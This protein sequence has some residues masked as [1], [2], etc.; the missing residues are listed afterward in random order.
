MTEA[1][2]EE[3]VNLYLDNEIGRHDL[4]DLKQVIREN[5]LRRLKFE[6]ACQ[7]HQ[8][9][10]K[11][12]ATRDGQPSSGDAAAQEERR[13]S[14]AQG[15]ASLPRSSRPSP[16]GDTGSV[17][18][19]SSHSSRKVA[20]GALAASLPGRSKGG[21]VDL[22]KVPLES[23]RSPAVESTPGGSGGAFSFFT[24]PGGLL[25]AVVFAMVGGAGLYTLL[26]LNSALSNTDPTA[27][28]GS[29]A[30]NSSF[31]S[32]DQKELMRELQKGHSANT[33]DA[34]HATIYQSVSG[35]P[36]DNTVQINYTTSQTSTAPEGVSLP[37]GNTGNAA[38]SSMTVQI[39]QTT[40]TAPANGN[41]GLVNSSQL[42]IT[43]PPMGTAPGNQAV[44]VRVSLPPIAPAAASGNVAQPAGD[45]SPNPPQVNRP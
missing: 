10:R 19:H 36:A 14:S 31:G 30:A 5:A 44:G 7:L 8:A 22:R 4:A 32:L 45:S 42:Q 34:M 13:S 6:R 24:S 2:F 9:A 3:L 16:G 17:R 26:D 29:S 27:P 40:L 15:A 35:Q 11:A 39:S 12:L 1:R 33:D 20:A 43:L 38:G 21:V 28:N 41:A 25:I 18:D 37:A 23:S